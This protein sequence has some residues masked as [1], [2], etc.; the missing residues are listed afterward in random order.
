MHALGSG[1][2]TQCH[3]DRAMVAKNGSW[4]RT[5]CPPFRR[6]PGWCAAEERMCPRRAG[7]RPGAP[8]ARAATRSRHLLRYTGWEHVFSL[9]GT[10]PDPLPVDRGDRPATS[11]SSSST[12]LPRNSKPPSLRLVLRHEFDERSARAAG[13]RPSAPLVR[14]AIGRPGREVRPAPRSGRRARRTAGFVLE[15]LGS[16]LVTSIGGADIPDCSNGRG[17]LSQFVKQIPCELCEALATFR[18]ESFRTTWI[19]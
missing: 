13:R 10:G 6:L 3:K 15:T 8:A 5:G 11:F 19:R 9:R 16:R 4:P 14:V 7:R 17:C 12:T 1:I 18:R 2:S